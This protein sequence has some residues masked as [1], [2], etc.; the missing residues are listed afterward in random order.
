VTLI[1]RTD[2]EVG[3]WF[4]INGDQAMGLSLP[5]NGGIAPR[6]ATYWREE[7]LIWNIGRHYRLKIKS[8]AGEVIRDGILP[9]SNVYIH[10][11]TSGKLEIRGGGGSTLGYRG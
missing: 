5:R 1:N 7:Q 10:T 2:N 11:D 9:S 8:R 4:Y 6:Q 3:F